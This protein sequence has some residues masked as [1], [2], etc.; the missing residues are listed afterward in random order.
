MMNWK[1][2]QRMTRGAVLA[3]AIACTACS[4]PRSV[5]RTP[6]LEAR[7]LNR[8]E[9]SLAEWP[10]RCRSRY[11]PT[12]WGV[13]HVLVCGP[14]GAPPVLMLH[15]MGVTS[16][17]WSTNIEELSQSHR[18]YLLDYIGDLGRSRLYDLDEYP[19]N[20]EESAA[21]LAEVCRALATGPVDVIGGSY[22]GWAALHFARTHPAQVRRV[23]LLGPMGIAPVTAAVLARLIDLAL[24]PTAEKKRAMID[25]TLG[26]SAVVR[27]K[28]EAYMQDAMDARSQLAIP[29][30][31][32]DDELRAVRAPVLLL[33]GV[34]DGPIGD[35]AVA[36]A[37]ARALLPHVEIET[38]P[39][40]HL[41][42]IEGAQAVN[43][44]ILQFLQ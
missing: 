18:V 27:G 36:E 35:P 21:F 16:M 34:R 2:S 11:A 40:G 31:L 17:V 44:R 29:A 19:K 43:Q 25:W 15:P 32:G 8:Y 6:D 37:R 33:L 20:G 5:Y 22:G 9:D 28:V 26:D 4:T 24:F 7:M 42:N 3:A 38:L 14:D 12:T 30:E 41:M 39:T 10:V 1:A 13:A 23:A